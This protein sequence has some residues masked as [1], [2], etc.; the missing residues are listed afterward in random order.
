MSKSVGGRRFRSRALVFTAFALALGGSIAAGE[1]ATQSGPQTTAATAAEPATPGGPLQVR[2]IS[3]SQYSNTLAAIFGSDVAPA[4]RFAPVR[5][6]EGLL[7]AG[8]SS[9]VVTSG[10][11]DLFESSGREIAATVTDQAHRDVLVGCK[12]DAGGDNPRCARAFLSRVGRLLFRRP[13]TDAELDKSM[14]TLERGRAVGDFYSGLSASLTAMLVSPDFL[15]VRERSEADPAQPAALRLDAA[16]RATRLSLLLWDSYPDDT[17]LA[18]AEHGDLNTSA[19]LARQVVR[20]T[21]SPRLE[22][23]VRAFFTDM[24]VLENYDT[25]AKDAVIYPA[26]TLKVA[27]EAREQFL[28]TVVDHVIDRDQDY[29]DLFTTRR[30]F[31]TMDLGSIYRTAVI[32][33]GSSD[34]VPYTFPADSDRAGILSQAGFLAVYAHAGRS[35]STRRGRGIRE[36]VLCQ[37]IPDPPPNVDFSIIEDPHAHFQTARQRLAAHVTDPTCAGCHKRTDPVGLTL[38]NFDGAGQYRSAEHGAEIDA[39]GALDGGQPFSGAVGL[40][41]AV[42]DNP[43]TAACLVSRVWSYAVGRGSLPGENKWINYLDARFAADGYRVKALLRD[44]A[45]SRALYAVAPDSSVKIAS[46]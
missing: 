9:A 4:K 38:E 34:W 31:M 6:V 43:A 16:S 3:T 30:T 13:L 41:Q 40:G 8:A 10:A 44:L 46:R 45:T 27:S 7:A 19:G 17:L 36:V 39:S 24:F 28:R 42:H 5:R 15:F 21:S 11:L 26:F 18:A 14:Q 29:R 35:S 22:R 2:L 1:A 12:L 37:H 20:M 32:A 23:G 25:L 33:Q